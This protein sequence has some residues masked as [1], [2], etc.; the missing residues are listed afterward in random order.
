MEQ[1][2]AETMAQTTR[3]FRSTE[4]SERD[5]FFGPLAFL[6]PFGS[7]PRQTIAANSEETQRVAAERGSTASVLPGR[8]TGPVR[9]IQRVASAWSL[10]ND[11]LASLLV[12]PSSRLV[13]EVLAGRL[14]LGDNVDRADRIRLLYSIHDT[15]SDIFIDPEDEKRWIR[16]RLA[17]LGNVAPLDY[18]VKHRIPGMVAVQQFVEQRLANR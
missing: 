3:S 9:L 14:T 12:Y 8:V 17:D 15:L 7:G 5:H 11:E 10:A 16:S 6:F 13:G 2:L 4:R 1:Q 18:M